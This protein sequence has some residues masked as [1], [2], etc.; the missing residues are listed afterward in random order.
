MIL[1]TRQTA[2]QSFKRNVHICLSQYRAAG[3][4]LMTD[5]EEIWTLT[6]KPHLSLL[7]MWIRSSHLLYISQSFFSFRLPALSWMFFSSRSWLL[8]IYGDLKKIICLN[9]VAAKRDVRPRKMDIL[10]F[11]EISL[12]MWYRFCR[13]VAWVSCFICD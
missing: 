2:F 13:Q 6:D 12:K 1:F 9:K 4:K 7:W 11:I 3:F 8:R 5:S 10:P